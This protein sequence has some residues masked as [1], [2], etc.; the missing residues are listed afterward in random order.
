MKQD[1]YQIICESLES[2]KEGLYDERIGPDRDSNLAKQKKYPEAYKR[3]GKL[4]DLWVDSPQCK[5]ANEEIKKRWPNKEYNGGKGTES[6]INIMWNSME[7]H[8]D[9]DP[10]E[11]RELKEF[12]RTKMG[13]GIT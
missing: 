7:K 13:D 4:Y 8:P 11:M 10:E 5:K 3:A 12:I 6:A 2:D 9:I 1:G